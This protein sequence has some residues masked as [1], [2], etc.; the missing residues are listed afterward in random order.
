MTFRKTIQQKVEKEEITPHKYFELL[1]KMYDKNKFV[2]Q[3]AT[4]D[5]LDKSEINRIQARIELLLSEIKEVKEALAEMDKQ[6]ENEPKTST[7]AT[8]MTSD[9]KNQP[10]K[11]K[12]SSLTS[13]EIT[14]PTTKIEKDPHPLIPESTRQVESPKSIEC[15]PIT[16]YFTQKLSS[17]INF[18]AYL[19]KHFNDQREEEIEA[20]KSKIEKMKV[21]LEIIQ[22][23]PEKEKISEIDK[24]FPNLTSKFIIGMEIK[25]RNKKIDEII[26]QIKIDMKNF[27]TPKLVQ[28]FKT[29]YADFMTQINNVKTS[30]TTPMPL[31]KK[32]AVPIESN[33]INKNIEKC[34]LHIQIKSIVLPKPD[35]YFWVSFN[36]NY[37][38]KTFTECSN[39]NDKDGNFNFT[40]VLNLDEGKIL[41]KLASE[42]VTFV[43]HKNKLLKITSRIV[44]STVV[45][46]TKLKN[47]LNVPMTLEF[48]Y[49]GNKKIKVN[50]VFRIHR[51]LETPLKD[52][53]FFVIEKMYPAFSVSSSRTSTQPVENEYKSEPKDQGNKPTQIEQQKDKKTENNDKKIDPKAPTNATVSKPTEFKSEFKFPLM[54]IAERE[55]MTSFVKKANLDNVF[56]EYQTVCFCCGFL[57]EFEAEI[58]KQIVF[59]AIS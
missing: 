6:A 28:M 31:I 44:S 10:E 45:T 41:K 37:Q 19:E 5:K 34:D 22:K 57:D 47:Y 25:E 51:A 15:H 36:F 42:K 58:E 52:I 54:T 56:L 23:S 20:L 40:K 32:K 13:A 48:D 53:E 12:E 11:S 4:S 33:E 43:L 26:E 55:R 21:K 29:N 27:N 1:Q 3:K 8:P 50:V 18:L 14:I 9:A 30:G 16:A 35:R 24:E 39:Y 38:E 59:F 46:L 49:K 2:L 17:H 7:G